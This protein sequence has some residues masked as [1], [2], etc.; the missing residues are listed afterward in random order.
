MERVC[1]RVGE[2]EPRGGRVCVYDNI[3]K[4][5]KGRK[6]SRTGRKHHLFHLFRHHHHLF[7]F[8]SVFFFAFFVVFVV[9]FVVF[10]LPVLSYPCRCRAGAR[11]VLVSSRPTTERCIQRRPPGER[12]TDSIYN[13]QCSEIHTPAFNAA[14]QVRERPCERYMNEI[15][16][17]VVG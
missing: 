12:E 9:V 8:S 17:P 2:Q 10:F 6:G 16:H 13:I 4:G 11:R 5:R 14:P 15:I 1:G 3:R 7:F